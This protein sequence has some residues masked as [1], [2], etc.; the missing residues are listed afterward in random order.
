MEIEI[1]SLTNNLSNLIKTNLNQVFKI[2]AEI[3][4]L[5]S[6]RHGSHIYC[7]L[8]EGNTTIPLRIWKNVA[9]SY[10]CYVLKNGINVELTA[11]LDYYKP[12]NSVVL[13]AKSVKIVNSLG[14]NQQL[15]EKKY[16]YCKENGLFDK[17]RRSFDIHK[18]K[19]I[20][21]VSSFNSAGTN[22]ILKTIKN[23]NPFL[24]IYIYDCSVQGEY[25]SKTIANGIDCM[26]EFSNDFGGLDVLL[27]GRGGGSKDDLDCFNDIDIVKSVFNSNICVI[28]CVGHEIDYTLI[29][30]ASDIRAMTP[31]AGAEMVSHIKLHDTLTLEHNN[32]KE[33]FE[34]LLND[35]N[36][37]INFINE[38][39]I[40]KNHSTSKINLEHFNKSINSHF[41]FVISSIKSELNFT[42]ITF[43]NKKINLSKIHHEHN[44]INENFNS[45]I[46]RIIFNIENEEIRLKFSDSVNEAKQQVCSIFQ[47][48]K[49]ITSANDFNKN[50]N[51]VIQFHD[52]IVNL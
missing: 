19:N 44:Y 27:V 25:A 43:N 9:S 6:I 11:T 52:G 23:N 31:T 8:K 32:V 33:K 22:D 17:N 14:F 3:C 47:N 21:I 48:G 24:N 20:G 16:N 40:E 12:R 29:D 41:N 13:I 51:F 45:L 42:E 15:Y 7:D 36:S 49:I 38:I 5:S 39:Y 37:Q 30:F 10:N 46:N 28:S 50:D 34:R 26:N 1:S 4:N 18:I 2:K 35:I